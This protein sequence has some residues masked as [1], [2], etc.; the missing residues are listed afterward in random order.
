[1]R[2]KKNIVQKERTDNTPEATEAPFCHL[3]IPCSLKGQDMVSPTH[4]LLSLLL[5]YN[6][7]GYKLSVS[8]RVGTSRLV[9]GTTA[10]TTGSLHFAS[11]SSAFA[12]RRKRGS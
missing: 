10:A 3:R 1:M 8:K 4:R 2:R 9:P 6:D 7:S 5:S 12:L 11:Y